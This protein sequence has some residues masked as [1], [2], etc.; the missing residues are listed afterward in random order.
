MHEAEIVVSD[1]GVAK[2]PKGAQMEQDAVALIVHAAELDGR[3]SFYWYEAGFQESIIGGLDDAMPYIIKGNEMPYN[4]N[5]RMFPYNYIR[6]NLPAIKQ[7]Y[8]DK[9]LL[10]G[11]FKALEPLPNYIKR[12]DFMKIALVGVS[13]SGNLDWLTQMHRYACRYGEQEGVD[14]IQVLSALAFSSTLLNG[15]ID[16]GYMPSNAAEM[17]AVM[18]LGGLREDA[19]GIFRGYIATLQSDDYDFSAG[20]TDPAVVSYLEKQLDSYAFFVSDIH[21]IITKLF[22]RMEAFDF[23]DPAAFPEVGDDERQ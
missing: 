16:L 21:P 7:K 3:N 19:R 5:V 14:E 18:R 15:V 20:F 1:G 2:A 22:H 6:A 11:F 12:K 8:P 13:L 17:K 9:Y 10:I 23:S 4:S